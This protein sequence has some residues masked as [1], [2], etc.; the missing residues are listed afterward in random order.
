MPQQHLYVIYDTNIKQAK[1][2]TSN[3]TEISLPCHCHHCQVRQSSPIIR[4]TRQNE[5][6]C[7]CM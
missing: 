3:T 5:D 4:R 6:G 2:L 1:R 7:N